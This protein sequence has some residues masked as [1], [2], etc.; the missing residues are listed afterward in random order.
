MCGWTSTPAHQANAHNFSSF[1]MMHI[2]PIIL[3]FTWL[4]FRKYI[5]I[6]S[7]ET[8]ETI[9]F[10]VLGKPLFS[11]IHW[12]GFTSVI[13]IAILVLVLLFS[14]Q[15]MS[16][17]LQ[18]HKLWPARLLCPWAFPSKNTRVGCHF[19]L[20]GIFPTQGWNSHLLLSRWVFYRWSPGKL[21]PCSRD[22]IFRNYTSY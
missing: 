16:A 15:V 6:L 5:S 22:I 9:S 8:Y 20:Q 11:P 13:F 3:Y 1:H 2:I 18:P 14:R 17:P 12:L 10:S 21:N 7:F 4:A 19:L